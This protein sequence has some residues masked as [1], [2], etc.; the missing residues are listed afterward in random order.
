[1]KGLDHD[2]APVEKHETNEIR[3]KYRY[4]AS[5]KLQPGQSLFKYINKKISII[6]EDDYEKTTV[7]LKGKSQKKL[8]IE[9]GALYSVALNKKNAAKKFLR[10]LTA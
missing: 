5:M 8:I 4:I 2:I 3:E 6:G 7:G 10:L 9:K 1:M